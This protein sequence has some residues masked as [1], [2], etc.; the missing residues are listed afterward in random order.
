[1]QTCAMCKLLIAG[2]C[3]QHL[4][5]ERLSKKSVHSSST[6]T[7]HPNENRFSYLV[8]DVRASH[9]SVLSKHMR[10]L[11]ATQKRWTLQCQMQC[12]L[13]PHSYCELSQQHC[14]ESKSRPN[15]KSEIWNVEHILRH[16]DEMVKYANLRNTFP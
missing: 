6:Q 14:F 1:M 3:L 10:T 12:S 8:M 15:C 16:Q 7:L 11:C 13:Y 2:L 5:I 4:V 9:I